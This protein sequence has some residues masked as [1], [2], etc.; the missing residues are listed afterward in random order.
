VTLGIRQGNAF[1]GMR[2]HHGVSLTVAAP[3]SLIPEAGAYWEAPALLTVATKG[4]G[5]MP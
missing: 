2:S 1:R 4:E 5:S 3:A